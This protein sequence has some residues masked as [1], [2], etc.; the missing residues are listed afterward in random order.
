MQLAIRVTSASITKLSSSSSYRPMWISRCL[1]TGR[2]TVLPVD[3]L[4]GPNGSSPRHFFSSRSSDTR[5]ETAK[6]VLKAHRVNSATFYIRLDRQTEFTAKLRD[7]AQLFLCTTDHLQVCQDL[8]DVRQLPFNCLLQ[9]FSNK[10]W[11][12]SNL[13]SH[14]MSDH[15]WN[16]HLWSF[17]CRFWSE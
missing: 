10:T 9:S 12:S 7:L 4:A 8:S 1:L 5:D 2:P 17:H 3:G 11:P 13:S 16:Y 14:Q 6:G 15:T